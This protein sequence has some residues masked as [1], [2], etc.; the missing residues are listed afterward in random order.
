[1][2]EGAQPESPEARA[3]R[4]AWEQEQ[5]EAYKQGT[6]SSDKVAALEA[7]PGWQWEIDTEA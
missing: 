3:R 7:V 4:L 2:T 6:L 5:R 1:M